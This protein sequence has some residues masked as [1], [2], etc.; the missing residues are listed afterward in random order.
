[1]FIFQYTLRWMR[2]TTRDMTKKVQRRKLVDWEGQGWTRVTNRGIPELAS[3]LWCLKRIDPP[4]M[5]PRDQLLNAFWKP[6]LNAEP[7]NRYTT[8]TQYVKAEFDERLSFYRLPKEPT[9]VEANHDQ[10]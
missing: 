10:V 2:L 6:L 4:V 1:M 7:S 9:F 5:A 8:L 3:V